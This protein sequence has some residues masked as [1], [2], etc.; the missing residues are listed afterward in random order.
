MGFS[1]K[2]KSAISSWGD[3]LN[4]TGAQGMVQGEYQKEAAAAATRATIEAAKIA[5][6]AQKE[7]M[8]MS[9]KAQKEATAEAVAAAKE[10][11]QKANLAVANASAL[12]EEAARAG[13]DFS[14]AE[15]G[16]AA[17]SISALYQDAY[18]RNTADFERTYNAVKQ[19]YDQAYQD[20]Q[21]QLSPWVKTGEKATGQLNALM[22]FEGEEAATNAL[23]RDPSY[24][25]RVDQGRKAI[26]RSA[27]GDAGLLTGNTAIELEK[28]GQDMGSQEFNNAFNRLMALSTQGQE[29]AGTTAGYR[30]KTGE[31]GA[32][33]ENLRSDRMTGERSALTSKE[34]ALEDLTASRRAENEW[35]VQGAREQ[36]ALNRSNMA[37]QGAWNVANAQGGGA[38][39]VANVSIRGAERIGDTAANNAWAVANAKSNE[40]YG[41]AAADIYALNAK[42]NALWNVVDTVASIYGASKGGG[43]K[44]ATA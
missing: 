14:N 19:Q 8:E 20:V 42:Q 7:A 32:L 31:A 1:L 39:N 24:K 37:A 17:K 28:Y 12:V 25:W 15:F 38:Q 3:P 4:L 41:G 36:N 35:R 34:A 10:A 2:D 5:A 22:G 30:W 13:A 44:T 43:K 16:A 40:A 23:M 6:A 26:E 9:I 27:I 33:N 11:E 29:A 21:G 18:Q